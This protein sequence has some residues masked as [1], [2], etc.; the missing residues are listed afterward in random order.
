MLLLIIIVI[1]HQLISKVDEVQYGE[2]YKVLCEEIVKKVN[3]R[4]D[5]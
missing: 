5:S 4:L 3:A 2:Q 1:Y